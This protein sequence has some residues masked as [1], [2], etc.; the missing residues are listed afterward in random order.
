MILSSDSPPK[1]TG[2]EFQDASGMTYTVSAGLEVIMALGSLKTPAI[3]QHSGIGPSDVLSKAGVTQRVEL[4]VGLNLIDQT[5]TTTDWMITLA[6]GGGQPIMFP[7]FQV[8]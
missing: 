8:S 2:L 3:L 7:R 5:T 1:A 6:S 4:P